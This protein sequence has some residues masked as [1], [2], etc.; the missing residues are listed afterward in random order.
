MPF[1]A[2]TI[3][4]TP[5]R[6]S[7]TDQE[8]RDLKTLLRLSPLGP[9]TYENGESRA[10]NYG[11]GMREM[12]RVRDAWAE[13]DWRGTQERLNRLPQYIAD[14]SDRDPRT[15]KETTMDV[16]FLGYE[17]GEKGAVPVLLLHGWPGMGCYELAPMVEHLRKNSKR[18]LDIIIPR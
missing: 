10:S 13:Y 15:G 1:P 4:I 8:I 2:A 18:P 14:V 6:I 9:Q 7:H 5:F 12:R 11:I 16:H 3:P 17:S